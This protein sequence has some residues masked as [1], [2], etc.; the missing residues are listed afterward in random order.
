MLRITAVLAVGCGNTREPPASSVASAA[1][2]SPSPAQAAT[3]APA[4]APAVSPPAPASAVASAAVPV[5]P[6][7]SAKPEASS[8][9]AEAA[10]NP[11]KRET[12]K[13]KAGQYLTSCLGP[14]GSHPCCASHGSSPGRALM[15]DGSPRQAAARTR[16]DWA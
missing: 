4:S 1:A 8:S 5:A 9:K 13:C 15:T 7:A 3:E 12:L 14:E 10:S 6:A 2:S 16:G 11:P